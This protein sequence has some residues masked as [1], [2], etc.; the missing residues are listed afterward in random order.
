MSRVEPIAPV[1]FA[2]T[3]VYYAQGMKAGHWVFLT[4]H[5]AT[6]FEHGLAPGVAGLPDFPLYGL[7]KHRREGDF[8]MQ[9]FKTLL[10]QA[11][12]DLLHAVRLDQYYPTWKAV[13][14]YHLSRKAFM[15]GYIAPST[16]VLMSECLTR[17]AEINS[18]LLAVVPGDG[19]DPR[20]IHPDRVT[21]PA[22]SGFVP[23]VKSGDY[24]FVAGQMARSENGL[25]PKAHV[26]PHSRWGGYEIR[27][28]TEYLITDKLLPSLAAAGSSPE[29]IVKIQTYLQNVE[30]APHFVDVWNSH[31][32]QRGHALSVV[33]TTSFGLV[34]GIIE[35]NLM[36][37]A[38]GGATKKQVVQADLP[39]TMA[40]GAHAVRAGDLLMLSALIAV[41]E[42]GVSAGAQASGFPYLGASAQAQM[43]QILTAAQS[44]CQA[45]GTSLDNLVR[46]IQFH[47]D[48]QD[49]YPT[50]RVWQEFLPGQP[51]P[52]SAVRV[53]GMPAPGCSVMV[54]MWV[55]AP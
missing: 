29:N 34:D 21:A 46:V 4:G 11:G 53:P 15:G 45:A 19:R 36:A 12:T 39:P 49:F 7:P 1:R 43:R 35:I 37:L 26:A 28:Q 23:V 32:G 33:P 30:D 6:D 24:I 42:R 17:G 5:E 48:L 41:D 3:D 27:R 52:F 14:P 20:P 13:D 18:S 16:S 54:D 25:D 22:W 50:Y 44:I 55:Y 40:Y 10:E 31:F 2:N 8:I 9:R 38:N 47:T 51:I